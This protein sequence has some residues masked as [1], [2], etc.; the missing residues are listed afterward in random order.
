MPLSASV[1]A[2]I[3]SSWHIVGYGIYVYYLGTDINLKCRLGNNGPNA[4]TNR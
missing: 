4:S 2:R 1:R 3:E